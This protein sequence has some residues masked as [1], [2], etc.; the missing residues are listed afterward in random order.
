MAAYYSEVFYGPSRKA[1]QTFQVK[2]H[3]ATSNESCCS[4]FRFNVLERRRYYVA[5]LIG[6]YFTAST[7]FQ[8]PERHQADGFDF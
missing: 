1:D 8:Y 7:S 6:A 5:R 2:K 3:R 4:A